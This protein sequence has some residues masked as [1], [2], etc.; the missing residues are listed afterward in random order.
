MR[1]DK[2]LF[3]QKESHG[4]I[5][6][7]TCLTSIPTLC[8]ACLWHLLRIS[9]CI[10]YITANHF[11]STLWYFKSNLIVLEP[12]EVPGSSLCFRCIL[13]AGDTW[14]D[15]IVFIC[16]PLPEHEIQESANEESRTLCSVAQNGVQPVRPL[17]SFS[18]SPLFAQQSAPF[19][20]RCGSYGCPCCDVMTRPLDQSWWAELVMLRT[21]R[22]VSSNL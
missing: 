14:S 12:A 18:V 7:W 16:F 19:A 3:I 17:C 15:L 2:T 11:Q 22:C 4:T 8:F 21:L 9:Y 20:S 13:Q 6:P 10:L 1:S 5:I